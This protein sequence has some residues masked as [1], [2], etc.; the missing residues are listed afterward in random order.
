MRRRRSSTLL[1]EAGVVED[2]HAIALG[3]Q[4]KQV[5]DALPL[6]SSSSQSMAVRRPCRR[7]SEVSGTTWAMVSQFLLGCSVS[8]PVR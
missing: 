4:A 7:C 2:Q 8:N 3:G 1:G 6:R 5:L